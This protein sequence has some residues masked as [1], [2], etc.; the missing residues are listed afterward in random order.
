MKDLSPSGRIL[1]VG[2]RIGNIEAQ[3]KDNQRLIFWNCNDGH[4]ISSK[5]FPAFVEV[6]IFTRFIKHKIKEQVQRMARGTGANFFRICQNTGEIKRILEELLPKLAPLPLTKDLSSKIPMEK[7]EKLDTKTQETE[8][9]ASKGAV[10]GFITV[11]ADF[12]IEP[13]KEIERLSDLAISQGITKSR[14]SIEIAYYRCKRRTAFEPRKQ[15][16]IN[17]LE[18]F[19]S[20]LSKVDLVHVAFKEIVEENKRLTTENNQLRKEL[21]GY[22]ELKKMVNKMNKMEV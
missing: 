21:E 2:G 8:M 20:S 22:K 4:G 1:I 3:F 6:V 11:N 16:S 10:S 5:K 14:R 12:T 13:K 7:E 19:L 9:R 17:L 15:D 18:E